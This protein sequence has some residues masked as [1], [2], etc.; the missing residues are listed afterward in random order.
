MKVAVERIDHLGLIAGKMKELGLVSIIDK[1][2][3]QNKQE[4]VSNGY[5][6]LAMVLNGL[7]FVDRPLTLISQFYENKAL[8]LLLYPGIKSEYLNHH[9]LGRVL[10]NISDFGC[11]KFFDSIA[12]QICM[13]EGVDCSD[14]HGDTTTYSVH[15]KY[16][17][18]DDEQ[19]ISITYGYSKDMRKDLKQVV[20]EL[21]SARDGGI[22]LATKM[23]SGNTSDSKILTARAKNLVELF[24]QSKETH[25]FVADSKVYSQENATNLLRINFIT[26]IPST[27]KLENEL[28]EKAIVKDDWQVLDEKNKFHEFHVQHLGIEQRWIVVHSEAALNRTKLTLERNIK[29]EGEELD[30]R[31]FHLQ[32]HRFA[33]EAD[34]VTELK[35]V[36]KEFHLYKLKSHNI[37]EHK[38]YKT[39]GRPSNNTAGFTYQ[40]NA[41]FEANEL[42]R[43]KR[44]EQRSCF[45]IG[46]NISAEKLSATQVVAGY[47]QQDKV[48][49]GFAFL[50]SPSFFA[51]SVFLK[52]VNRIQALLTVM[53]LALLAYTIVQRAIRR[54]L[55]IQ[56]L[57][58]PNQIRQ[59]INRPTLK[60]IFRCFEG[61]NYV[62]IEI[63]NVVQAFIEGLNELRIKII[64]LL[65]TETQMIYKIP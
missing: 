45:V 48:E 54:Q 53:V 61:V 55:A 23:W 57:T 21:V 18:T 8:D 17:K 60:W 56:G 43:K 2:L 35:K 37:I 38:C 64:K 44:L 3:G 36:E 24:K 52:N 31:L 58:I 33:C 25:C 4:K 46:T 32:A 41:S 27:I 26:R 51:S 29:S 47:K 62:K 1:L 5:A 14:L 10:D 40:M 59:P 15:G 11:E 20:V 49:K 34:A 16:E 9:R 22:P 42:T 39:A 19:E 13:L 28:I 7:G 65:G 63:D 30:K 6:V 12:M 50:K